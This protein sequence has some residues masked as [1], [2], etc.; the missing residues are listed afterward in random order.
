[1]PLMC[2]FI[3]KSSCSGAVG[4]GKM[5]KTGRSGS[6]QHLHH[7]VGEGRNRKEGELEESMGRGLF[8][9]NYG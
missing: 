6:S 3:K 2:D 7:S 4:M 1:M 9:C 5:G 8:L